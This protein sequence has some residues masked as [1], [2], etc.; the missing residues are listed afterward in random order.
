MDGDVEMKNIKIILLLVLVWFGI[1]YAKS[2]QNNGQFWEEIISDNF[3]NQN[4]LHSVKYRLDEIKLISSISVSPQLNN[5]EK[6]E[7]VIGFPS[8]RGNFINF[9]MYK[10]PVMPK[11]L[12]DKFPSI[13]TY[14]GRGVENP[15]DRVSVTLRNNSI[16]VL[17]LCSFGRIFIDPILNKGGIYRVSYSE[18][19]L[20]K[21]EEGNNCSP[22]GCECMI[23][24]TENY[25]P[26]N[27]D[28]D[29]P[30]CVGE[31]EP[32][33]SI[34]DTLVTFRYAG[35]LTAEANNAITDGTVEGGLAWIA[36]MANQVNLVWVRELSFRLELIEN[37]DIL[38][39]TY[40]NPTPELFTAYDMYTE[41]P[42]VL[43]HLNDVIGPGGYGVQE[44]DLLWE[45]GAV[46]NTGYGGGLAYV[47]GS[48]SANLPSYAVH[49]HE[50]GHNLGSNHN[51][52]SE[53][54]WKSS[55]GGTAMCSRG[56][57]LPGSFGDQYSSHTIDIAIR[58]QQDM[59]SGANY[60]YQRG[61]IREPSGNNI[62]GVIIPESGFYIPQ[63]TPFILEGS[64]IDIDGSDI[65]SYSWEQNDASNIS[66]SPPDFPVNTG[67][68]FCSVDASLHGNIRVFPYMASVLD[69][70]EFTGNIERLPYAGREMNMRLLVRDNNLYSGAFNYKNVQFFVDETTGPFRVTSQIEEEVWETGST[71]TVTWDVA[72]TDNPNTVN[73]SNVDIILMNENWNNYSAVIADN[74][75]NNG[76]YNITVPAL[77]ELNDFRIMVKSSDNVFF[78]LNE[79][80]ISILNSQNAVV[81]I[82]TTTIQLTVPA[83]SILIYEREIGN[84]GDLG[85]ILIYEPIVEVNREGEGFLVFDGENDYVDLGANILSGDGD[86][87]ITLW[88]KSSSTNAVIIQQRNGG[89]NGEYQLNF[90]E[91][92]RINFWTYR[93]GYKWSVTSFGGYNDSE[94]HHVAV[95]QDETING[96]RVY[97]DGIE[98][99][100]NSNGVVYLDG[101]IH[102][103]L[104]ADIRDWVSYLSG[105][106]N[107]V[108]IFNGA[109][110]G[111]E[112]SAVFNSGVGFN[113]SYNHSGFN[114]AEYLVASYPMITMEDEILIDVTGNNHNGV[115][116]GA[117]WEGDLIPVPNWMT[118][119]SESQWLGY[120]EFEP[121]YIGI[122]PTELELDME[123]TGT[124]IITS[125]T[126]MSPIEI[127]VEIIISDELQ[128]VE[129]PV[130]VLSN[131]NLI[132][133]PVNVINSSYNSIFPE[134]VEGTLY[135]YDGAY[136]QETDLILGEGYWLRFTED[137][138]TTIT[139][140]PLNE[141]TVNLVEGWNLVSGP[142][143]N[144]V[145]I[146]LDEI[147]IPGT[148]YEFGEGYNNT[149][150]LVPG[151]GYWIRSSG[152]GDVLLSS[153]VH[154]NKTIPFQPQSN[155]NTITLNNIL[156]YFGDSRF[157]E[158]TLSY[159]LP[160]KPPVGGMDIRFSN[161][162]KLCITNECIIEVINNNDSL[163]L[164]FDIKDGEEWEIIDVSGNVTRCNDNQIIEFNADIE[165]ILLRRILS[166][167]IP[168]TYALHSA[169]PNP[170]NPITS[171]KYNLPDDEF[172]MLTIYNILGRKVAQLVNNTQAA[173]FNS[174]QW[175]ATDSMGRPVSAG[176]Y[177]YQIQAGEF[178]QTNK[179]VLL[180]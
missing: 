42:R 80:N 125:N 120:G 169:Y 7:I 58:Y 65:L 2:S 13:K 151:R 18:N 167:Q 154:L 97:I 20:Q 91:N 148:L 173:G 84:E 158:R 29:F 67:P 63:N 121:I 152:D 60:D 100:T 12:S 150:E 21:I 165:Q 61:W 110:T 33:Y 96:G 172:V 90:D 72:N 95:V 43:G 46:F 11:K 81:S 38:I 163:I 114:S 161:D 138:T 30:Y 68:L 15:N 135:G 160:P 17:M 14:T 177:L 39:Y 157:E 3:S 146:D 101:N 145:I 73:C 4:N 115:I 22:F 111:L 119:E 53:N 118:I 112:V 137:G 47:P 93:N 50:I 171:I 23:K 143:Q 88:V 10:S 89:F 178:V 128:S 180:K 166:T 54:G 75:P 117:E 123:Y 59:F 62:P 176:V 105:A 86:F 159:S 71:Q 122:D 175:D 168:K 83:D 126:Q 31:P 139:G 34:G 27:R 129:I 26:Q 156:L 55:F 9:E 8:P 25:N 66:F 179:M 44:E 94:W 133:L 103:C 70:L 141:I 82:D 153:T 35:I 131:W 149:N 41:L 77:P 162:N 57:T 109:L 78:D 108:H 85:S 102:T 134:S 74:V 40:E 5:T 116:D 174:V 37:N 52:T 98:I 32:C 19:H 99:G 132:G 106:I 142:S 48:T 107:D 136:Q 6:S 104:G 56:N 64:A 140:E 170:F 92:G 76:N 127:P 28:R 147:V 69:N 87:S 144:S 24:R 49:I 124:L 36:A 16:K 45:Y 155:L 113:P 1:L 130:M 79:S 164:E 51:C